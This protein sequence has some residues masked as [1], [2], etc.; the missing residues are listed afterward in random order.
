MRTKIKKYNDKMYVHIMEY[1]E[2]IKILVQFAEKH[3]IKT[4]M[5]DH[6]TKFVYLLIHNNQRC[7]HNMKKTTKNSSQCFPGC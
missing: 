4:M 3:N 5:E 2:G 6:L 7:P 1:V